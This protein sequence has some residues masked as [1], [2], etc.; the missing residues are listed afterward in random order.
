MCHRRAQAPSRDPHSRRRFG[1]CDQYDHACRPSGHLRRGSSGGQEGVVAPHSGGRVPSA[2]EWLGTERVSL[3]RPAPLSSQG[4]HG[5]A[6]RVRY[7]AAEGISG[8][9]GG[10]RADRIQCGFRQAPGGDAERGVLYV[11]R[12][13]HIHTG[14][15]RRTHVATVTASRR[16]RATHGRSCNCVCRDSDPVSRRAHRGW[17]LR[18]RI[19]AAGGASGARGAPRCGPHSGHQHEGEVAGQAVTS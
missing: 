7:G 9:K 19:G 14:R 5:C 12:D 8:T 10:F 1:R 2:G 18:G 6:R 13:R 17:V 11:G 3:G 16:S 4:I 15:P